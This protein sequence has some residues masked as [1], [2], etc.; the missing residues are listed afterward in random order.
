MLA[1]SLCRC[2]AHLFL[3]FSHL[4]QSFLFVLQNRRDY[5][6]SS[7]ILVTIVALSEKPINDGSPFCLLSYLVGMLVGIPFLHFKNVQTE[8]NFSERAQLRL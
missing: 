8:V 3:Y 2:S 4:I 1:Y 5:G 7:L 6:D